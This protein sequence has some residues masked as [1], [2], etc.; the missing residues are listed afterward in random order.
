MTPRARA[1]ALALAASVL[2]GCNGCGERLPGPPAPT[3]SG[4]APA[5][6]H[7]AARVALDLLA[8][9]GSCDLEHRGLLVD[10]GTEALTGR[11][12]WSLGVPAGVESTEHD[13]STWS[14]IDSRSLDLTVTLTE[15]SPVFVSTRAV[16]LAARSAAVYLDDQPLGTLAFTRD[17][18]RVATTPTTTLPVDP[19]MHTISLRFSSRGRSEEAFAELDWLRVGVPDEDPSTYGPPTLRD[20][21][22]PAAALG[23]VPRRALSLRAPGAARCALRVPPGGRLRASVG[24]LGGGDGEAEVRLLRDQSKPEVLTSIPISGGPKAAWT[25]IDVPLGAFTGALVALEL[26]AT[27]AAKGS[28]VLFGDPA[29]VLPVAAPPTTPP[30]RAV[31]VVAWDGVERAELPPWSGAPA[32]SLPTFSELALGGATFDQHRGATTVVAGAL[33]SMLTALPPRAHGL[34]DLGAR[35]PAAQT[36]IGTIARDASVRTAFFSG[37]PT[38]SRPF[39]FG[40][41]WEKMV[42][43]PPNGGAPAT[44][45]LDDAAAWITEVGKDP[46]ARLLAVIH[47]RGGHPPWDI[48]PKELAAVPPPD[49]SGMVEPRRAA[50]VLARVRQ[51]GAGGLAPG[52]RDRVRALEAI[53]MAG[54]DRALGGVVAALKAT[55]L[56]DATLLIVSGDVASGATDALFGDGLDLREPLLAL[57]L[58][59]HFPGGLHGGVR[60]AVPTELFDVARTSLAALGLGFA[61]KEPLGRDLAAVASGLEPDRHPQIATLGET[62]SARWGDLVLSGRA[63]APP[64]LCDLALDATCAFNRREAMPLSTQALF[65]EVVARDVATR[66]PAERREPATIDADTAA[67]LSVW[68]AG[69]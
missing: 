30:A 66:A 38:T 22:A 27:R 69:P 21:V 12:G 18:I 62:Y 65:R 49:Y 61:G 43:H 31:V 60:A 40:G 7:P 10:L 24:V 63:G 11:T 44:A 17:V 2:A 20:V 67:T 56:W 8:R 58:Y 42:E 15:R 26:R 3:S 52:D 51:K 25:E 68:G 6:P 35:L 53:A 45:P 50:Q 64:Q 4:S 57:P 55:G 32:P 47:A 23:G 34:T 9:L 13:G 41:P 39:G 16:G 5:A 28:R 48:G 1:A 29:V 46:S 36:T 19:G 33:A 54:Q 14:R 37:V 59:V